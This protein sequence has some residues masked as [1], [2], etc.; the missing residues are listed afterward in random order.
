MKYMLAWKVGGMNEL[1]LTY[2]DN[3][4]PQRAFGRIKAVPEP[5]GSDLCFDATLIVPEADGKKY[6]DISLG[7]FQYASTAIKSVNDEIH[8]VYGNREID[9]HV[10]G[11]MS[12]YGGGD[13]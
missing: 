10:W 11:A 4:I 9:P 8:K 1:M 5:G 7:K 3:H 13:A 2:A 12:W 6:T